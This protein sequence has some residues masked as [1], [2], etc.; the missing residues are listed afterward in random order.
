MQD[1]VGLDTIDLKLAVFALSVYTGN[2]LKHC[3]AHYD[4][5]STLNLHHVSIKCSFLIFF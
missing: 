2:T 1:I 5:K 3:P 4:H